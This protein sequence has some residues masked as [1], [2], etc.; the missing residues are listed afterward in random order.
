MAIFSWKPGLP[1]F[2][3]VGTIV[4]S[5]MVLWRH[6]VP[7]LEGSVL[8]EHAHHAGLLV[9]HVLGGLAMLILGAAGLFIGWTRRAF[10]HHRKVGYGYLVLG[11]VG[12]ATALALSIQAPHEPRSLYVATGTLAL[13]WLAVAAMAFRAAKHRRIDLHREW[14]IRSYLLSWTF[15]GCRLAESFPLFSSLGA[16]GITASIWLNWTVPLIV[17]EFALQWRKTAATQSKR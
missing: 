14:M 11:S 9:A 17:C 2:L 8:H 1:A 15:V 13:V 16:E 4:L 3:W 7:V 10:R 12:A 6:A 5:P